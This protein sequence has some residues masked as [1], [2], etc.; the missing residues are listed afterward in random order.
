MNEEK[1]IKV[2]QQDL[3]EIKD[4]VK[5]KSFTRSKFQKK[6]NFYKKK[7]KGFWMLLY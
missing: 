3:L 2:H 1:E 5:K 4:P 6:K 7:K